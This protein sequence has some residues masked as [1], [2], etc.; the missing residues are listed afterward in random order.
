MICLLEMFTC[1]TALETRTQMTKSNQG[2]LK[3]SPTECGDPSAQ[4]QLI[5]MRPGSV[6]VSYKLWWTLAF[7][8]WI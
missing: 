3:S 8:D 2:L 7:Q 6:V 5:C 4:I 1:G